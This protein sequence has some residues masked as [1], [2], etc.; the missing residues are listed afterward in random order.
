MKI[1]KGLGRV[2]NYVRRYSQTGKVVRIESLIESVG[3]YSSKYPI[4]GMMID[5]YHPRSSQPRIERLGIPGCEAQWY[6]IQA[7]EPMM[8]RYACKDMGL[9]CPFMVK[10][11][12]V[13][14]VVQKALE[15]VLEKHAQD[16]NTIQTEAQID[17][18]RKS[19]ARSTRIVAG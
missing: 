12:N 16:F 4:S 2:S 6:G 1:G 9:N 14:E 10:G 17:Q 11:E 13:D 8:I 3:M 7:E 5:T 19:L 18:M 15:H